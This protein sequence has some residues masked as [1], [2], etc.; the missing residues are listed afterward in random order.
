[1]TESRYSFNRPPERKGQYVRK[2]SRSG[3]A[4]RFALCSVAVSAS[5]AISYFE[6]KKAFIAKVAKEG[7]EVAKKSHEGREKIIAEF[8]EIQNSALP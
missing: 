3:Y 1:M 5:S 8:A 4:A 7:A 2:L 6:F